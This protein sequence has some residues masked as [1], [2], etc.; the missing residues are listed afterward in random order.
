M[1]KTLV[2]LVLV[3]S[4]CNST[5]SSGEPWPAEGPAP[6]PYTAQQIREAHPDGTRIAFLLEQPGQER[7][8]QVMHFV[9]GDAVAVTVETWY[10]TLAGEPLG[11]RG[12]QRSAWTELRDHAQFDASQTTREHAEVTVFAGT[13]DCQLYTVSEGEGAAAQTTRYWFAVDK[14]GP[15]VLLTMQAGEQEV[16]R[17]ELRE[18]TLG[19]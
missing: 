8:V 11:A 5:G 2:A 19:S 4:A 18:Y 3:A 7:F 9:D 10:E 6:T 13:Y 14:P 1:H 12:S 15:P 16:M 17:M